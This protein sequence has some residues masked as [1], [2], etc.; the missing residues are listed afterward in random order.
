[1]D[2]YITDIAAFLPND[3]VSNEDMEK[4]LGVV[5]QLPTRVKKI[6]L[7]SNDI[8]SRYYAINPETGRTSHTNAQLT[9]E[10]VRRLKPYE[11][12]S[13][14]DIECLSCGTATPDQILPGHGLMV[15]GELKNGPCEVVSTS[16]ICISG[17]TS[18]KYAYMNVAL[19]F[20]KNAVATGSDSASSFMK[21]QFFKGVKEDGEAATKKDGL[22]SFD[23]AFLRWMLSDGAGA[24]FMT[25]NR[26]LDRHAL[27]LDW[28]ENISFAGEFET[29]MYAGAKKDANGS[30][31]G[32]R[33][34]ESPGEALND[35]AFL[36]QQ[37]VKLL[38]SDIMRVSVEKTLPF[39]IERRGLTP[40]QVDWLLPHYSSGYFRQRYY[41]Q[42]KNFGFEI[43]FDKWFTNLSYK[44]NTGAASIY[45]IME[46]LFHS[47][48]LKKGERI[49]CFIPE[50]GRF[51][52]CY[53]ML[54]VV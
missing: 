8:H 37:D 25:P 12:F 40:S 29:C 53:M 44:G 19:G 52:I 9:A 10:A 6:V 33:D 2:V 34:Y 13:L 38:N 15:H 47:G 23:R 41:D 4:V 36:I 27:R 7:R 39:V 54:T 31:T 35:G 28:I 16:S 18:L 30:V 32:W 22:L 17:M 11:G 3:P 24:V 42:L 48:R 21:A 45:I 43:P 1:M 49:L 26:T 50:S 20:T 14:N 5:S 46:E 51:S